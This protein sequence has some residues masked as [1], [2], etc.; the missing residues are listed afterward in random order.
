MAADQAN[1]TVTY[2]EHRAEQGHRGQQPANG[3]STYRLSYAFVTQ[4]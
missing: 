2:G 4:A 3:T 1:E